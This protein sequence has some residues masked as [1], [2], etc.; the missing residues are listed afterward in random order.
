MTETCAFSCVTDYNDRE[1]GH[2]G[3]PTSCCEIKLVDVP[4]MDY[5][6]S[7]KPC[8][9]GEIWIRGPTIF[10]GYYKMPEKTAEDITSE[11]WFKTGDVGLWRLD[12][13]LQIIDRKKSIIGFLL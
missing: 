10:K 9:R 11:G 6:T 12:G 5:L 1:Y 7:D 4:E 13:N 2:I 8:S 3:M